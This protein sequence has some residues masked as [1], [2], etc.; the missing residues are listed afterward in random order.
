MLPFYGLFQYEH[1]PAFLQA[2]RHALDEWW[3]NM[4]REACPLWTFIY[5]T[6]R[7]EARVDL[8]AAVWTLYRMPMDTIEWNVR[9]SHRA[10]IAWAPA[11]DRFGNRQALTLL[12]PDERPVMKWNSNPFVVDGGAGGRIE[13]DGAAFLLPYWLG[14]YHKFLLGE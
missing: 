12:P 7:P 14:R 1:D 2:Y 8:S 10:D 11:P 13:D 6:G 4:Q 5:L 9:N 3:Q